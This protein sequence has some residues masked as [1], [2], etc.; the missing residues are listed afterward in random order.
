L[1][2]YDNVVSEEFKDVV[3]QLTLGTD[4]N[5]ERGFEMFYDF[6]LTPALRIIPSYQYVWNP[7]V[8]QVAVG[9]R[10][11]SVFLLRLTAVL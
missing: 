11:A 5:N 1:G 2:F 3:R 4:V 10:S 6:A 7:L 9:H 8:A